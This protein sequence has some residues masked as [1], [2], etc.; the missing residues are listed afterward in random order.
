MIAYKTFMRRSGVLQPII[1]QGKVDF[2]NPEKYIIARPDGCGPF[3]C[4]PDYAS[5]RS[6][7]GEVWRVRIKK[8]RGQKFVWVDPSDKYEKF[9]S[10]VILADEFEIL[11]EV[12]AWCL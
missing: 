12:K 9:N 5:A 1:M 7:G 6:W 3:Q 11:E 4:Y 10:D 2:V 8:S